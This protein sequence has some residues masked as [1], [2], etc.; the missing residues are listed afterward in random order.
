MVE[1]K[2]LA[3]LVLPLVIAHLDDGREHCSETIQALNLAEG[4]RI[5]LNVRIEELNLKQSISDRLR[6]AD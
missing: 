2:C 1:R 6:L 4:E 3:R 5:G